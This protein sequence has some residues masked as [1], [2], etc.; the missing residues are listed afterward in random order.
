MD[1]PEKCSDFNF[2]FNFKNLRQGL[3]KLSRLV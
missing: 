2:F 1:M 3:T